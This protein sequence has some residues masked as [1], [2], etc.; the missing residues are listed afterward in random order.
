MEIPS[1]TIKDIINQLCLAEMLN[2]SFYEDTL[3]KM[4]FDDKQDVDV[5]DLL[6]SKLFPD[7]EYIIAGSINVPV[8]PNASED[9]DISEKSNMLDYDTIKSSYYMQHIKTWLGELNKTSKPEL[10]YRVS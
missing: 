4:K 9:K 3:P 7:Y 6:V 10:L 8:V 2:T 5:L 1:G